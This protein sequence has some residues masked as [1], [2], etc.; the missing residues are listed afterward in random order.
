LFTL[1]NGNGKVKQLIGEI[2]RDTEIDEIACSI[3]D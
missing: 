3:E 1:K 2:A